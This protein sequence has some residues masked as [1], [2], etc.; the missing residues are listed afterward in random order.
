[1][2]ICTAGA[3]GLYGRPREPCCQRPLP[4]PHQPVP[5]AAAAAHCNS[6][7]ALAQGL[8]VSFGT[9]GPAA[10][11]PRLSS[12]PALFTPLRLGSEAGGDSVSSHPHTAGT[13]GLKPQG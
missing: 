9:T 7:S 5:T 6:S 4:P 8:H 1:M 11:P 13:T 3:F 2:E 10:L 12:R